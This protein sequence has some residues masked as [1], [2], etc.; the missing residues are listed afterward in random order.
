MWGRRGGKEKEPKTLI[1]ALDL[2][3]QVMKERKE[4]RK[5]EDGGGK[6]DERAG[7]KGGERKTKKTEKEE[8]KESEV[9]CINL[10]HEVT[11]KVLVIGRYAH[12]Q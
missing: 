10:A 2:V 1:S 9:R 12:P 7:R 5:E 4:E 11:A 8:R 6:G 3:L